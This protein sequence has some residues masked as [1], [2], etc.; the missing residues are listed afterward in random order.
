MISYF[1]GEIG[2]IVGLGKNV[3]CSF[4]TITITKARGINPRAPG[5]NIFRITDQVSKQYQKC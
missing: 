5:R 2:E 4:L 1:L 3:R